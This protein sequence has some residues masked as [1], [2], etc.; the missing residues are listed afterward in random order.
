[1]RWMMVGDWRFL[2]DSRL[3]KAAKQGSLEM[4]LIRHVAR[5]CRR[6]FICTG[7]FVGVV[8]VFMNRIDIR[9]D[10]QHCVWSRRVVPMKLDHLL[11]TVCEQSSSRAVFS[12]IYPFVY[13]LPEFVVAGLLLV[14]AIRWRLCLVDKISM[15]AI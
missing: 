12:R 6:A 13:L 10:G 5:G 8:V 14:R 11:C 9:G 7:H 2:I 4:M 1:M 15:R 3:H